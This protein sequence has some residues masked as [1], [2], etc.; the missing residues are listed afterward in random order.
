MPAVEGAETA[1]IHVRSRLTTGHDSVI[2]A[3][4]GIQFLCPQ[5][6]QINADYQADDGK[7]WR[8]RYNAI[9]RKQYDFTAMKGRKNP[10]A[11]ALKKRVTLQLSVDVIAYFEDLAKE[12]GI[13]YQNLINLYLRECVHEGKRPALS[14]A[15]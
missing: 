11:K 15:S 8:R 4:A 13:P 1:R 10:Y 2:P 3:E 7:Q 9:M 14:R 6:S 5:I 12:T